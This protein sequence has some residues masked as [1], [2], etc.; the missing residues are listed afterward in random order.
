M[1]ITKELEFRIAGNVYD[2]YKKNNIDVEFNK[3]NKLPIHLVNPE[4]HLIVDA[5]CDVCDK[6][7][8]VQYRRYNKSVS[9]S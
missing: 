1:L 5:V 3:I 4:S 6:E 2:Y 8:K 7:V 9:G